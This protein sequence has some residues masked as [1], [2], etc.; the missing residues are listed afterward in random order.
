MCIIYN[1]G[2]DPGGGDAPCARPP[3]KIGKKIWFFGV[4]SW[5]F[6]RNTPKIF[7]PPSARRNFFKCAP[8]LEILDPPLG[9][10]FGARERDVNSYSFQ[11]RILLLHTEMCT[12]ATK[13]IFDV[14]FFHASIYMV[15]VFNATYNISVILWRDRYIKMNLI[16]YI[17]KYIC[18]DFILF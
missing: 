15:M 10:V 2:A 4:K 8:Y 14:I 3:P 18:F 6:R 17:N 7:A 11:T 1:S 9:W 13:L 5:F 16:V 12:Y